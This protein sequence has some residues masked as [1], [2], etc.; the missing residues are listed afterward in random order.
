MLVLVL[1]M[2]IAILV[3]LNHSTGKT[4]SHYSMFIESSI[5]KGNKMTRQFVVMLEIVNN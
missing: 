3:R 4:L 2:L 1:I 5:I